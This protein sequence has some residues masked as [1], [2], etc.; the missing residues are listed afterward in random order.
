VE[1]DKDILVELQ[2]GRQALESLV[3]GTEI[4]AK[5]LSM[6]IRSDIEKAKERLLTTSRQKKAYEALDGRR[7]I[8]DIAEIAGYKT[9]RTLEGSLPRWESE[10]MIFSVGK[11]TEKRYVSIENLGEFFE[12][13]Q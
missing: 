1:T 9:Q 8:A 7:T 6:N 2:K 5:L 10:G 13:L 12:S 11:A 3:G 4:V